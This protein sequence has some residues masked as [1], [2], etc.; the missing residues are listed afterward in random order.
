MHAQRSMNTTAL[1]ANQHTK[2]QGRPIWIGSSAVRT[3]RI[4]CHNLSNKSTFCCRRLVIRQS[5]CKIHF[6]LVLVFIFR[7]TAIS[8][9][10]P[11]S[12]AL[13]NIFVQTVRMIAMHQLGLSIGSDTV[14]PHTIFDGTSSLKSER[15]FTGRHELETK[16]AIL[17]IR[18]PQLSNSCEH[19]ITHL[20]SVRRMTI[21]FHDIINP[22]TCCFPCRLILVIAS[23]SRLLL[24]FITVIVYGLM[25]HDEPPALPWL[26]RN[27]SARLFI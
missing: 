7:N 6:T 8:K 23:R 3:C 24:V 21:A 14:D 4:C 17:G 27:H 20:N 13:A 26:Q 18:C 5:W 15:F 25:I 2:I 9:T 11:P 10:S 19:N 1:H 12:T 22:S 16:P